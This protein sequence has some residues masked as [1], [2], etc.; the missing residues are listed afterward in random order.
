MGP[1]NLRHVLTP[2]YVLYCV[3]ADSMMKALESLTEHWKKVCKRLYI[4][5]AVQNRIA[6]E[7]SNDPEK[8]LRSSISYWLPMDPHSSWRRLINELYEVDDFH[9]VADT[10]VENGYAKELSGQKYI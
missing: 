1:P 4:P 3:I 2:L 5:D 8:C 10:L 7:C 6:E 9:E